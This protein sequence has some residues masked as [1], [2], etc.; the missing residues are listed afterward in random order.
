MLLRGDLLRANPVRRF[1]KRRDLLVIEDREF[2]VRG[3]ACAFDAA[4]LKFD[5]REYRYPHF[6]RHLRLPS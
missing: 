6:F 5:R 2:S 3:F 4:D 1:V